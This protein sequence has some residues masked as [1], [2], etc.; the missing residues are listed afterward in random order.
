MGRFL[1]P[2]LALVFSL[3]V[4]APSATAQSW[5]AEAQAN[6][7]TLK[8]VVS[9]TAIN[10]GQTFSYTIYFSIPAGATNVTISDVLPSTLEFLSA[11][12][13]SPCGAPTV[14]A[15]A[16]NSMGGT[17][18]LS[19]ASVP[20]GCSGSFTITVRFPNGITCPGTTARNRVCETAMLNGT[21]IDLCTPFVSTSALATD[22]W[23]VNKWVIG[24]AYQ[25]GAC[26]YATGDSVIS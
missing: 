24:A 23:E 2:W 21:P 1:S 5:V 7:F 14:V 3:F 16:V 12:F 10:T 8:K 26:P 6:G 25:G 18:S 4:L 19:W 11:S 20:G 9:D 17:Y 15:P 22:P 13:T